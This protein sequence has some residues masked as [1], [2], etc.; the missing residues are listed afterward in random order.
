MEQLRQETPAADRIRWANV[1]CWQASGFVIGGFIPTSLLVFLPDVTVETL[2]RAL[3]F[4]PLTAVIG[5]IAG[6][7]IGIGDRRPTL[8][9]DSPPVLAFEPLCLAVA[10]SAVTASA[11][12]VVHLEFSF[13]APERVVLGV[14]VWTDAKT[15]NPTWTDHFSLEDLCLFLILPCSLLGSCLGGDGG[16]PAAAGPEGCGNGPGVERRAVAV[17]WRIL[18][19]KKAVALA[20]GIERSKG[21]EAKVSG[22]NGTDLRR[23]QLP[24]KVLRSPDCLQ[25]VWPTDK[26]PPRAT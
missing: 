11:L 14:Q 10:A 12:A 5:A 9:W 19:D 26:R 18:D 6:I 3:Y 8:G 2:C 17:C 4:A 22:T 21:G 7:I 15:S 1:H 25:V 13:L 20:S 16:V 23:K 24:A